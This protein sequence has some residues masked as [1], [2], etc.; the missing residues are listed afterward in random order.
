M[1]LSDIVSIV[2]FALGGFILI[3]GLYSLVIKERLCVSEAF[4]ALL[5]GILLGPVCLSIINTDDWEHKTIFT[6]QFS[7]IVIAIQVMATGIHLPKT[8]IYTELRSLLLFLGPVMIWMWMISAF[9]V[10]SVFPYLS[11]VETLI[12]ASCFTPTDPVL[13][14]SILQ[15]Q[16]AEKHVPVTIR[17]IL[18][19]ESGANDGLGYPFLFLAL[20]WCKYSPEI[21]IQKWTLSIMVYD[22]GFAVFLGAGFG[23]S[24]KLLLKS[25]KK[26]NTIDQGSFFAF[27]ITF[28]F[29]LMGLTAI[30][31][32]DDLLACFVA[33]CT[34]V[35]DDWFKTEIKDTHIMEVVDLLLNLSI[36]VYIG[37]TI[38]WSAFTDADLGMAW[39]KLVTLAI[40]VVLFRRLPIV[41][42]LYPYMPA[43]KGFR[44]AL[45]T[46]FFGPLGIGSVFYYSVAVQAIPLLFGQQSDGSINH[47][48]LDMIEPIVYFMV[49]TSIIVHGN[50]IT[51][52]HLGTLA[53]KRL[54]KT[55]V[56]CGRYVNG[57]LPFT[58]TPVNYGSVNNSATLPYGDPEA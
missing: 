19:A 7:R 20:Y 10:K 24:A 8:Y 56:I 32:C 41:I 39:S 1:V 57:L 42:A 44:Q 36:F 17:N 54:S 47:Q 33:G 25:A 13:S 27:T 51:V 21:A 18:S 11:Y 53:Y 40:L 9:C 31:G 48:V 2:S 3:F 28:T 16:F 6:G 38:P 5:F 37:A 15:G 35:W 14:N 49:I 43:I 30:F 52:Y 55:K 12:I 22:I 46:G 23:Y 29:F 4:V 26:K 50:S 58:E 34:L 45:F